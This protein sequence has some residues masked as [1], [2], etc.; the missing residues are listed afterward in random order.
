MTCPTAAFSVAVPFSA[1]Q[2]LNCS[3][4]GFSSAAPAFSALSPPRLPSAATALS[5]F[6]VSPLSSPPP[7]VATAAMTKRARM[8]AQPRPAILPT[9][10]FLGGWGAGAP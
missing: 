2:S 3:A 10:R 8:P 5:L 7:P 6:E 9:P 1:T 4:W